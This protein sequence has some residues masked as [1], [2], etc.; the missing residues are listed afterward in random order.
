MHAKYIEMRKKKKEKDLYRAKTSYQADLVQLTTCTVHKY[1][2]PISVLSL[3]D[4]SPLCETCTNYHT[5]QNR[6]AIAMQ[7]L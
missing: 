7:W 6:P 3:D 5:G 2:E 4:L 1:Y